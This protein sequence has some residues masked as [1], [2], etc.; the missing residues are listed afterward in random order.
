MT[1]NLS[2]NHLCEMLIMHSSSAIKSYLLIA[3]YSDRKNHNIN[4]SRFQLNL[5]KL[6]GINGKMFTHFEND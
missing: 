5:V 4:S 2:F 3:N 1:M 6:F